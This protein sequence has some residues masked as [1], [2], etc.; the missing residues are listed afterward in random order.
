MTDTR[1]ALLP[2]PFCGNSKGLAVANE[3]PQDLSGGYFIACPSCDAST[4]LRFACGEDPIPLLIEQ[5]NRRA[6]LSAQSVAGAVADSLTFDERLTV[7]ASLNGIELET[8]RRVAAL[9]TAPQPQAAPAPEPSSL[10]RPSREWY[11]ALSAQPV[12][13]AVAEP[14]CWAILTPNGS[15]LV[16]PDEAKGRKDAYPLYAAPQAEPAPEPSA[17]VVTDVLLSIAKKLDEMGRPQA[18]NGVR[19]AILHF[20]RHSPASAPQPEPSAQAVAHPSHQTVREWMPVSEALRLSDLWTAGDLDN[21]GQWRAAIK[22]LADEVR[23]L[24]ASPQPEPSAQG[25]PVALT[26]PACHGNGGCCPD[27][28]CEKWKPRASAPS[29]LPHAVVEA[30]PSLHPATADLVRRFSQALAEKLAA[31]EAKYGYSDGWAFPDWMDECR[32]KLM[33]HI[34]KGDPRDVAAYCAFLWHHGASTARP[35]PSAQGRP[36]PFGC[37]TQEE[38]DAHQSAEPS[39]QGEPVAWRPGDPIYDDAYVR[40]VAVGFAED[41]SRR[42]TLLRIADRIEARASAPSTPPSA[43]VE[44]VPLTIRQKEDALQEFTDW[45]VHNYPGPDTIISDPKWHAPKVFRQVLWAIERGIAP[46]AAQ[47]K[48]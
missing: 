4:G 19:L 10:H 8:V 47:E 24:A 16:S 36:C 31:A 28:K 41:D 3:N 20:E 42:T 40:G 17:Q 13:G 23:A 34:A 22:V 21:C 37:T 38:H 18:A 27:D 39:A 26:E 9:L 6:A 30:V 7:I 29:T 32:A 46:K 14:D 43:V 35:E 11:A 15:K 45:F 25:E 44:A 12:A 33:E 2:C 5:W 1:Q 48:T